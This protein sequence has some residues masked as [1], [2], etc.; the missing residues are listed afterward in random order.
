[1]LSLL[2][3]DNNFITSMLDLIIKASGKRLD[4][5]QR[6][7]WEKRFNQILLKGERRFTRTM[8]RYFRDME[9]E[10]L[11]KINQNPPKSQKASFSYSDWLFSD[12]YWNEKLASEGGEFIKEMYAEMGREVFDDLKLIVGSGAIAGAFNISEATVLAFIDKYKY[13]FAEGIN[14]TAAET[15][16]GAMKEGIESGLGME[17]ISQKIQEAF[18]GMTSFRSM[19]IARTEAIRA[20]NAG[21][22]EAYKQSGVVVA[23]EWLVAHDDRLCDRCAPM[24]GKILPLDDTFAE[25]DYEDIQYPPLHPNCRCCLIPVI[26]KKYLKGYRRDISRNVSRRIDKNG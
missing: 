9:R 10:V 11:S 5:I 3:E 6:R 21:Q 20:S 2:M 17:G 18:D 4:Y 19:L 24:N 25:D 14:T 15:L 23:K 7:R 13:K 1:M 12:E 8:R 26:N 16:R 22:E